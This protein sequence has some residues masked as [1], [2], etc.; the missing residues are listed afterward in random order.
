[1]CIRIKQLSVDDKKWMLEH[2]HKILVS[3]NAPPVDIPLIMN[4]CQYRDPTVCK[5]KLNGSQ[6]IKEVFTYSSLFTRNL[7]WVLVIEVYFVECV[8]RIKMIK[9]YHSNKRDERLFY[10][11]HHGFQ[12]GFSITLECW[13]TE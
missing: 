13:V 11:W 10:K 3:E 4:A 8:S 9:C 1:M 7:P 6:A 5:M 12:F 2:L